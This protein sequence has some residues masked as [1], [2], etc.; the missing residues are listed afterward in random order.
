MTDGVDRV[1]FTLS[2]GRDSRAIL[3]A[4][5][6]EKRAGAIT[7]VTR[8]N[9][10]SAV[11][12]RVAA[13]AG[14]PHY[15]AQRPSDFYEHLMERTVALQG[16]EQRGQAH[17]LCIPDA[18]LHEQFDL[19]VSG[20]LA[21][22]FLKD[23]FMPP[24]LRARATRG[25]RRVARWTRRGERHEAD[26]GIGTVAW[27]ENRVALRSLRPDVAARVRE[28]HARRLAEVAQVRPESAAEWVGIWP[29]SRRYSAASHVQGNSR[30]FASDVLYAHR[31]IIDVAVRIPLSLRVDGRLAN[32]AFQRLY[33]PLAALE[34]A[35][36]GLPVRAGAL[37]EAW[38]QWRR[39]IGGGASA[40]KQLTPSE[41]PW[42]DVQSSWADM[43]VLQRRS[44]H[45]AA[46]RSRLMTAPALDVLASIVNGDPRD[47]L[48]HYD[49]STSFTVNFMAVQ[50]AYYL[51]R[52][53]DA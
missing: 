43:R 51:H 19:I 33:G 9:R 35:N 42:N 6:V 37:A 11:A 46:L 17:G 22:T 3:C 14:V 21:D 1:G 48:R 31:A 10:E 50:L 32:Q 24:W 29:A 16:S 2:G 15:F 47:W 27:L 52:A 28:R 38:S 12:R 39:R 53:A 34:D 13:A 30:T 45:W 25:A 7:Y 5:P 41:A 49:A 44:A 4:L 40:F 18:G 26:D 23:H 36:T 8:Q 20:Q